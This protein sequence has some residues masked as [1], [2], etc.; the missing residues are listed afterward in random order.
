MDRIGRWKLADE[1]TV[2]QIALLIAG[3]D[4]SEFDDDQHHMWPSEVKIETSAYLSA[5]KNAAR[6][7]RFSFNEVQYEGYGADSINW[8]ASTVNIESF[9]DW[10]RSRNFQDGFFI[11]AQDEFDK[12]ANPSGDFYAPKLAAAVRAWN[13]VTSSPESL[14]GKTPK[15]A[16]EI[17]LR[18][19]ANEYGLTG[20]DGNPNELGIEEI[21]KV[22]NWKPTG[23]ASPTPVPLAAPPEDKVS[24]GRKYRPKPPTRKA[25]Q[26]PIPI[27]DDIPF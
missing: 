19:H 16:L 9:C 21:C 25:R 22:A 1:L 11:S 8:D 2:Y 5:V 10:L 26:Q 3:Y 15:K 6:S 14:N 7:K 27:D 12:L 4:P 20:K 23:G 18:K 24:W 17:W 13:E